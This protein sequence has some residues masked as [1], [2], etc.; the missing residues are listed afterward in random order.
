M[1]AMAFFFTAM[2]PSTIL[3]TPS[4]IAAVAPWNLSAATLTS[5][6]P[7]VV[8]AAHVVHLAIRPLEGSMHWL[9]LF[10]IS[11]KSPL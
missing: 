5:M 2:W 9:R 11:L 3:L 10:L 8:L 6:S 4:A 1:Q 7:A